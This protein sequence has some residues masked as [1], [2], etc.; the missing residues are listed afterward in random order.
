M[1][2]GMNNYLMKTKLLSVMFFLL[3]STS[4]NSDELKPF[5]SDGRSAFPE[6]APEQ[7]TLWLSC[8]QQ[9]DYAYWQGGDYQQRLDADKA[10][11]TCVSKVGKPK[12]ALLMLTGVRVGGTPLLPTS[13]RWGYGW[14]YPRFYGVLTAH[15]LAQVD[16]RTK[17]LSID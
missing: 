15:E 1:N 6:G 4:A 17:N 11:K 9:H 5:T 10:L 8:C 7:S 2:N 13:F 12:V 16:R 14:T 3:L